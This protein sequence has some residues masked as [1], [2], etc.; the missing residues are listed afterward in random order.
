[1][2]FRVT[3]DIFIVAAKRTAFGSFG[4]SLKD[5]TATDLAVEAS[6]AALQASKVPLEAVDNVVFGN[7]CQSSTDAAY[8]ARH[9]GLRSGVPVPTPALTLN[10]LCG[11]GFQAAV[12]GASDIQLGS[13][14]VAL[15]GG[16]ESMSQA[17][18]VA[19]G[20]RWGV[21]LGQ[22]P[23]LEDS[24][25]ASLTDA[26]AGLPM[27]LT[28]EKLA[29]QYLITR[30][31]ADAYALQTQ[32]RW[33][34]AHQA[35]KFAAEIAPVTIKTGKK[36]GTVFDTDEGPRPQSTIEALHKL[37]P[38]FKKE[39]GTVTAGNASG[40][41]DGAA[42]LVLADAKAVK[43]YHLHPLARIIGWG[44]AGCDPTIMG[45][46]P[47]P[48]MHRFFDATGLSVGRVS[49]FEINEAFAP[50]FLAVQKALELPN[51]K[52]N[53]NGGAIA[54]GHPL[55]ASGARILANLTHTLQAASYPAGS[56]AVG[57]A[58][59]GGGSGIVVGIEKC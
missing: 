59:I 17:P 14:H 47:V 43:D 22:S 48:A 44:N 21:T 2:G 3:T 28:A 31:E 26:Y 36:K 34:A 1:M 45:I 51:D 6:K 52:T 58:C 27:G 40:I 24:L 8:L 33:A 37:V 20:I 12:T 53:L 10:R 30:A 16:T 39:G 11:S 55:A 41:S 57:G 9:V 32:L 15:V 4:G 23:A 49:L 18:F 56:I 35:G 42:A 19:R 54:L 25:W 13:S 50:Q 5:F 7:V 46:G 38:V 29:E